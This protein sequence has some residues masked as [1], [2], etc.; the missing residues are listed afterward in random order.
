ME[1]RLHTDKVT[2]FTRRGREVYALR[3]ELGGKMPKKYNLDIRG[4]DV[5]V[6]SRLWFGPWH[7]IM[8]G[9]YTMDGG[10]LGL[11]DTYAKVLDFVLGA[12]HRVLN[13]SDVLLR[14]V[15]ENQRDRE[16]MAFL[17]Q[18]GFQVESAWMAD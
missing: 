11:F 13:M 5:K 4:C 10:L 9:V 15:E 16:L 3:G 14:A 1:Y 2:V 17:R 8:H 7:N 6:M 12:R 18:S